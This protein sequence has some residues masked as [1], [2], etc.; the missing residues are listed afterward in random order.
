[1]TSI[2]PAGVAQGKINDICVFK[3]SGLMMLALDCSEITSHF[4][5][6]LG[7]APKWCSYLESLTVRFCKKSPFCCLFIICCESMVLDL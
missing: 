7:P 1:M 4:L 6:A 3:G 2:E 5:P